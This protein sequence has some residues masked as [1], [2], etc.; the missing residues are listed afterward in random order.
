MQSVIWH[1]DAG[2]GAE[3]TRHTNTDADRRI[4]TDNP[5]CGI[6]CLWHFTK[7]VLEA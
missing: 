7:R 3:Q 5:Y 1:T 4:D 6:Y 2:M